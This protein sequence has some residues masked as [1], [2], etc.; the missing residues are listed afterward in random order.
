MT[1]AVEIGKEF[2][3][4][5]PNTTVLYSNPAKGISLQ[6]PYNPKWGSERYKIPAY[7]EYEEKVLFGPIFPFEAGSVARGCSISFLQ[8]RSA[9]EAV[10]SL[11]ELAYG[12]GEFP[13]GVE[14]ESIITETINNITVVKYIFVD[15]LI[16]SIPRIEVVGKKYNYLIECWYGWHGM[17]GAEKTIEV[18]EK[19]IGTIQFIE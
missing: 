3:L 5:P 6:I 18:Y 9:E 11:K 1:Y 2:N 14:K 16:G 8:V 13:S 4:D 10:A 19:I 12:R 15:S 17:H 7:Y